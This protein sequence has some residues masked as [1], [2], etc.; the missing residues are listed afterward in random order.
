MSLA[1]AAAVFTASLLGSLHCAGMCGAFVAFAVGLDGKTP[2]VPR[3]T[4]QAA[5]H[6][7]RLATYLTLGAAAG[8]AGSVFDIAGSLVGVQR[9]ALAMAGACM[10]VFG[11]IA[12]L[13]IHGV[14]IPAAPAPAWLRRFASAALSAAST[15]SPLARAGLTGLLT[16]LLPCGWLYAFVITSAG[17]GSAVAGAGMMGVFWIGTLP[18][19]IAV[20][21][22]V[23]ALASRLGALGRHVPTVT[24]AAVIVIGMLNL[25][26]PGR[27][28]ASSAD[29]GPPP[30][31]SQIVDVARHLT[32]AESS[33][34]DDRPANP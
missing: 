25:V 31:P 15:Q 14:T 6:A 19:L 8:A 22:G 10:V 5:Y 24:A 13:R 27:L 1:L 9:A 21:S 34:C 3:S 33:C 16:T 17:T 28:R 30:P 18:A 26:A 32:P 29:Y 20:G 4:L 2:R 23:Q 11:L 12:V 7:G